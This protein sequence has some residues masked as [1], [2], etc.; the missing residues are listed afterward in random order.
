MAEEGK[1]ELLPGLNEAE[2]MALGTDNH[3]CHGFFHMKP[4]PPQLAVIILKCSGVP[5]VTSIQSCPINCMALSRISFGSIFFIAVSNVRSRTILHLSSH[6]SKPR[7]GWDDAEKA[8]P[9]LPETPFLW[10]CIS[11]L[12]ALAFPG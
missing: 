1:R 11:E 4:R 8:C 6:M 5:A 10:S 7:S 2:G 12:A 9:A 3:E